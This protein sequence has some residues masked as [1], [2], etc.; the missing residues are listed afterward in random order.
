MLS[1]LR[2]Q[3]ELVKRDVHPCTIAMMDLDLFKA[4]NDG[5][6]HQVGDV[7][8]AD[9]ARHVLR[10]LRPYD[11]FFRYG[12]EEFLLCA[13]GTDLVEG[14]VAVERLREGIAGSPIEVGTGEPLRVSASFGVTLPDPDASVGESIARADRAP[15]VAKASGRNRTSLWD[16]SM[17]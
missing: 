16:V 7:V 4:V 11:E 3:H 14:L 9:T 5:Y 10:H 15:Y 17:T 8:L 2:M 1:R 12:G 13:S 6:G